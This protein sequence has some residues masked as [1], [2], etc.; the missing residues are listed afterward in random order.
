MVRRNSGKRKP[1]KGNIGKQKIGL[2]HEKEAELKRHI[3]E[4]YLPL[5]LSGQITLD[6][7]EQELH[8]SR[9]TVNKIIEDYYRQNDDLDG[10]ENY[11][12]AK[13]KNRGGS[14]ETRKEAREKRETVA[15]YKVVTN[16]EFILL[17]LQNIVVFEM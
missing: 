17:S 5:I 13:R 2:Y 8:C 11:Q 1:F 12:K 15:N 3:I 10:L 16:N 14:L 4:Q 6:M 9:K 7:I